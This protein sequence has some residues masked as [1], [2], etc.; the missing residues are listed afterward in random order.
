DPLAIEDYLAWGYVPD[1][2]SVLKGVE[3][4]PAGTYRLLKHG[5]PPA[6]PVRWWDVSFAERRRGSAADLEAELLHHLRE[7]VTS[8]MVADVP[9]GAFLSGGV[10]SSTVVALMSEASRAPVKTCSIGF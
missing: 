9:L 10:D 2:R 8:R 7:A 5:T 1:H 6:E 4:L 3:K